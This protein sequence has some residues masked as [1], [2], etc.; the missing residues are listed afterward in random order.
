[1]FHRLTL[2]VRPRP[3]FKCFLVVNK[4]GEPT[5]S[6]VCNTKT[7]LGEFLYNFSVVTLGDFPINWCADA[8][9]ASTPTFSGLSASHY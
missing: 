5:I 4:P 9:Y 7:M 8:T 3:N 1:M 2:R 6:Q